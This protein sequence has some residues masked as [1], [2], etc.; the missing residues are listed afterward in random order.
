MLNYVRQYSY[1]SLSMSCVIVTWKYNSQTKILHALGLS[2]LFEKW[3]RHILLLE[4][5]VN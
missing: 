1:K 4:V 5:L 3:L 2:A